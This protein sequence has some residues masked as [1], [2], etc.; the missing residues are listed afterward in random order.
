[1]IPVCLIFSCGKSQSYKEEAAADYSPAGVMIETPALAPDEDI[2]KIETERKLIRE[3]E[4]RFETDD[5]DKTKD[6]V[7]QSVTDLKGY[8]SNE[9]VTNY[10]VNQEYSLVL[11]IPA[12]NFEKLIEKITPGIRKLDSKNIEVKDVTEEFVDAEARLKKKKDLEKRYT[13]LLQKARTV[14]EILN[15]EKESATLRADI[16]SIEGRLKLLKDQIAFSTLKITFYEKR[17]RPYGFGHKI[18]DALKNGWDGLLAF[19]IGLITIWPFV[20]ITIVLLIL[21]R[22]FLRRR[23]RRKNEHSK[24]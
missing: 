24:S 22:K 19:I 4:L 2:V 3:G 11:R 20:I 7:Q 23:N 5:A 21:L 14:E 17:A 10:S 18:G 9:S 1:M 13:E 6:L 8:I 15:I 12:E 16:E